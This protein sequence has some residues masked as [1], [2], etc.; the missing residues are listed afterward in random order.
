MIDAAGRRVVRCSTDPE[1]GGVVPG[2]PAAV[3]VA[4]RAGD[5]PAAGSADRAGSASVVVAHT[6]MALPGARMRAEG[7]HRVAARGHPRPARI[8]T[9]AHRAA[10]VSIGDHCRPVS[11][12]AAEMGMDWN[13]AHQAFVAY[14]DEGC[15]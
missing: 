4:E 14:A 11:G 13:I 15:W 7:V 2:V 9:R 6:E 12:V 3:V 1:F 10:A 8:T 5:D